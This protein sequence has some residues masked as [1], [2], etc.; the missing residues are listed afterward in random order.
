MAAEG[1]RQPIVRTGYEEVIPSRVGKM[2]AYI[3]TDKGKIISKNDHGVII[4]YITG[5]KQ[6]VS[7]GRNYGHAEGTTYPHDIVSP[8]YINDEVEK[9]DV[10]AYNEGFF[11]PDILN[12]KRIIMKNSLYAK[13]L[14]LESTQTHEDSSAISIKLSEKFRAKTTKIKSIVVDFKQ[15]IKN[16]IPLNTNLHPDDVLLIIEDEVMGDTSLFSPEV[17]KTLKRISSKAPK[18]KVKGKLDKIEVYYRGDLDDMSPSLKALAI[19]SD[20]LLEAKCLA[21]N[22]KIVTGK[23]SSEYRV[24]GTQLGIDQAEIKI[25]IT[26]ST[27]AGVGDKLVFSNQMKSVVGQVIENPIV[28]ESGEEIEAIFGEISGEKRIVLS[29]KIIGTTA[30]LL[31]VIQNKMVKIYE[32]G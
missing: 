7:L 9:G 2:F 15:G 1:Y 22:K 31:E 14:L 23:V 27:K 17:L 3:A 13:T 8:V 25:Y 11:E 28:T 4:E 18:S 10:I 20:K 24:S 29:L 21:T 19:K 32:E 30:S 6:G 16:I 12:S 5:E 26:R